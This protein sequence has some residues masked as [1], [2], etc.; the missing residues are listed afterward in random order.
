MSATILE[1]RGREKVK[2]ATKN[3]YRSPRLKATKENL[4]SAFYWALAE[5]KRQGFLAQPIVLDFT[6]E[7]GVECGEAHISLFYEPYTGEALLV[8]VWG[9]RGIAQFNRIENIGVLAKKAPNTI[10][11]MEENALELYRRRSLLAG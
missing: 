6:D 11:W 4:A 3:A 2:A 5:Q 1:F 10:K 9:A 8:R 7:E